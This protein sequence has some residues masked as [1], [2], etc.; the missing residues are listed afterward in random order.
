M[1]EGTCRLCRQH[2]ALARSHILPQFVGDWIKRTG[3][4]GR[5]R[6]SDAPNRPVQD[7][8]WRHWLCEECEARFSADESEVNNR[9]FSRLHDDHVDRYRYGPA[10]YRFCV[11]VCWRV[12]HLVVEEDRL[13]GCAEFNDHMRRADDMWR[14]YLNG[15]RRDPGPYD[16]HALPLD[17]VVAGNLGESGAALNRFILRSVGM[18]PVCTDTR[19]AVVAKMARLLV[20]GTIV[21]PHRGEWRGTK[22]HRGGGGWGQRD[23]RAPAWIEVD[24]RTGAERMRQML[25]TLSDKQKLQTAGRLEQAIAADPDAVANSES[26][27]AMVADVDMFGD[28]AFDQS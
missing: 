25:D 9:V 14:A 8:A 27:Q 1:L 10:F 20:V 15:E 6:L 11:S 18:R 13:A 2:R 5:L 16:F 4:T 28:D 22:L 12:L 21:D 7:P 23:Y 17:R 26:F 3:V 19:C 24:L